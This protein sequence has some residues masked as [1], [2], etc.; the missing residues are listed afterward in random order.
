MKGHAKKAKCGGKAAK[1]NAQPIPK[2]K[3]V[4]KAELIR[5]AKKV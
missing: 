4:D 2:F 1:T 5:Q 3:K